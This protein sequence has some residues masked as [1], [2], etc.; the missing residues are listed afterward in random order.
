MILEAFWVR[1]TLLDMP[2]TNV[3]NFN[4]TKRPTAGEMT[5]FVSHVAI[6]V[7]ILINEIFL[8]WPYRHLQG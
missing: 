2:R 1:Q 6:Q 5:T 3:S 4:F 8:T 7:Q